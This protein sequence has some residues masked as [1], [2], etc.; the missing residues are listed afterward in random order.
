MYQRRDGS[1]V[2][3]DI[4]DQNFCRGVCWNSIQ[5]F[6]TLTLWC[7]S[8]HEPHLSPK[9]Y[10]FFKM[11]VRVGAA[12]IV[13]RSSVH[14]MSQIATL[15]TSGS[16]KTP[17]AGVE[18]PGNGSK[19][20]TC[21]D[22]QPAFAHGSHVD[23]NDDDILGSSEGAPQSPTKKITMLSPLRMPSPLRSPKV[24]PT[25]MPA[26]APDSLQISNS[27][28]GSHAE[29]WAGVAVREQSTG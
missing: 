27:V 20:S 13:K 14:I 25:L 16:R 15:R 21:P 18:R 2:E 22:T 7:S 5:L 11:N 8:L 24:V 23:G 29:S 1:K 9:S 10:K 28:H 19:E 12:T 3:T 6:D 26:V 17:V 4:S